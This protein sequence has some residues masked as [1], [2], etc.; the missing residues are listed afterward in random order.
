MLAGL[1]CLGA[2]SRASLS[3]SASQVM[4]LSFDTQK[5]YSQPPYLLVDYAEGQSLVCQMR[6][7][8][9]RVALRDNV[10]LEGDVFV[11]VV[12][13]SR[14]AVDAVAFANPVTAGNLV[15]FDYS[16]TVGHQVAGEFNATFSDS[17]TLS[18]TFAGELLS[19]P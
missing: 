16:N 8:T 14:A 1:V 4:S 12:S 2:C 9:S 5:V 15:F 18:G 17:R 7:D 19:A 3:G 6:I 13:F 11:Q 10:K